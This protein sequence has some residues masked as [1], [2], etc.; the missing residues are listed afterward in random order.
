VTTIAAHERALLCALAQQVGPDAP[1]LCG[2][3]TVKELVVHLLLREGHPASAGIFVRPLRGLLDRATTK[4]SE[5]DFP[6]LVKRLRHGPPIYSPFAVPKLG[7]IANL[8]EF[9][10][11]HEDIRRAQPTWEPR[12]LP[13]A[14]EDGIW[15]ALRHL[16]RGI[17]IL[18]APVGVVAE[19]SDTGSRVTLKKGDRTVVI[20]GLPSEIALYAYGR[21]PQAKVEL[22]GDEADLAA[23]GDSRLGI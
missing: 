22:L 17:M 14:T 1:T 11:H 8:L 13:R 18:K 4:I 12:A 23:L 5:A 2:E 15:G 6:T 19:R 16:G 3:W 20:R 21:K 10:I 9:Y 7:A